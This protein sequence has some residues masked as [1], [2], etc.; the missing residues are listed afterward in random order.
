M[1]YTGTLI[2]ESLSDKQVLSLVKILSTKVED[3]T[4]K[5]K[6]PWLKQWTLHLVEVEEI[7]ADEIAEILSKT[8]NKN[9]WYADYKND[10][11]HYIIFSDKIFKVDKQNPTLYQDAKKYGLDLGI[12][13]YQIDFA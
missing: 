4:E 6:T 2:E 10:K 5:H 11:W 3:V 1:N 8:L 7:K 13:P 12:P 9:Y